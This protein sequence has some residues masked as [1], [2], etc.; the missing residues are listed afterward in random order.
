MKLTLS[1]LTV[2]LV[3][4]CSS[5]LLQPADFSWPI[6]DV[7][8]I[9]EKG[10]AQ[11]ERYSVGFNAKPLF[12]EEFADS[13]AA[14]GKEIRIIRDNPGFYYLTGS[15]FKNVY[16]FLPVEGGM[17]LQKTI[18]VADST[19]LSNPVFNQKFPNVELLDGTKK[20]LLNNNG[21]VRS[22]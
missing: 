20:Y 12:L 8:K 19:A 10:Y 21:I 22:K 17:K 9:D 14:A 13:N 15:G 3:T 2:L 1:L 5:V 6:E 16:L 11:I 4:G 7:L 18:E